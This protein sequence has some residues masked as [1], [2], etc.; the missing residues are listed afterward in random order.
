MRFDRRGVAQLDFGL[1]RI[2][3][4]LLLTLIV[5]VGSVFW[6][7]GGIGGKTLWHWVWN[8]LRPQFGKA[9]WASV[10]D[11]R[12][13]GMLKAGGLFMGRVGSHDLFLD[14]SPG[15]DGGEE[16]IL[17]IAPRGSGKT[18]GLVI[19]TLLTW[20]RG[21]VV[22][23][24]PSGEITAM[25]KRHR[26]SVSRVIVLSPWREDMAEELGIDLGSCQFNP[27]TVLEKSR[28]LDADTRTLVSMILPDNPGAQNP[29]W[30]LDA[31]NL[32]TALIMFMIRHGQPE[33]RTLPFLLRL[34]RSGDGLGAAFDEMIHSD[35]PL[36]Q[37]YGT[38]FM[39]LYSGATPQWTGVLRQAS[40]A[41]NIYAPGE[42]LGNHVSA[43][44]FDLADLKREDITLYLLIPSR[45][46]HSHKGWLNLMI[47]IIGEE[48]G[49][50]GPARSVVM[51]CDEFQNLGRLPAIQSGIAQYRK[52]GLRVWLIS[53]T[54]GKLVEIYDEAGF[55]DLRGQCDVKQFFAV[56][57]FD[58]AET[59]SKW[60]GEKTV[61]STTVG[62]KGEESFAQTGIPL[63]R[64][65]AIM[66]MKPGQQIIL[67]A[68]MP[69]I[70]AKLAPYYK[71]RAWKKLVD[72][73]PYRK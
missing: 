50:P 31:Q 2:H 72:P 30:V 48:V 70:K 71:R 36:I 17:T 6:K 34:L 51:I 24:D 9:R 68:G 26:E 15:G 61:S 42:S 60:V 55:R 20:R 54:W 35:D 46:I 59:L 67:K 39:A 49:R 23:T 12:R 47:T 21:S 7:R 11:M 18:S 73:N 8:K 38:D 40:T 45:R 4:L 66:Q 63:K 43:S 25:T 29:Y 32:L 56:N 52:A 10:G 69:P 64:S 37:S 65:D 22:I 14:D 3:V 16:C 62:G 1:D 19:P 28:D 57:D 53:Q 44:D 27:L 33:Q 5:A 13:A 41:L 58:L